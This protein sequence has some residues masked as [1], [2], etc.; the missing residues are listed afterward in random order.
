VAETVPVAETVLVNVLVREPLRDFEFEEVKLFERDN[1]S[2]L[3]KTVPEMVEVTVKVWKVLEM[4]VTEI[5][6]V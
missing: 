4:G 3:L 2:E 5:V 1:V 6:F